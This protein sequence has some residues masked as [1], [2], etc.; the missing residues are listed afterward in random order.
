MG[1]VD[2]EEELVGRGVGGLVAIGGEIIDL[3]K[4]HTVVWQ[5]RSYLRCQS[6]A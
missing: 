1:V 6:S 2:G 4:Q 5:S 3:E